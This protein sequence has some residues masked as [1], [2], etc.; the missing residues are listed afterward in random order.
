MAAIKEI[1]DVPMVVVGRGGCGL[2][3]SAFLSDYGVDH[4]LFE[5][6]SGTSILPKAH[7]PN[8]RTMET[9]HLH[10]MIDDLQ[11]VTCPP[12]NMSQVAWATPLGGDRPLD[13]KIIHK[14][15]CVQL[16]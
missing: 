4:Y 9:F 2:A 3:M 14:F 6:H 16:D 10:S 13:R 12:R 11:A 1:V 8:S 7:Y 5:R 15:G